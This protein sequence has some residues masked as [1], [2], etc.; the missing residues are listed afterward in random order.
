MKSQKS[1]FRKKPKPVGERVLHNFQFLK[2]LLRTRSADRLR[3]YVRNA[4]PDELIAIRDTAVNVLRKRFPLTTK[5][6]ERLRPY[7]DTAVNVARARTEHSVR[8]NIQI[9]GNAFVAALLAPII[10]EAARALLHKN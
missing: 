8:R 2:K 4:S 9:G 5:Q 1:T 10:V 6:K 3:E 7:A